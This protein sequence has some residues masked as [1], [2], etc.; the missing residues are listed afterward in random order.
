[1]ATSPS[2]PPLS[3]NRTLPFCLP[4]RL[5]FVAPTL[6]LHPPH[7]STSLLNMAY[8]P[9]QQGGYP[10]QPDYGRQAQN[11]QFVLD[12]QRAQAQAQAYA[13]E[14]ERQRQAYAHTTYEAPAPVQQ[15]AAP[16]LPTPIPTEYVSGLVWVGRWGGEGLE[17]GDGAAGLRGEPSE[18][19]KL[20]G[21]GWVVIGLL[22]A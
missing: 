12:Q 17:R 19:V 10:Q 7:T 21:V 2:R 9:P 11:P 22:R 5:A 8:R 18:S 14:R 16:Q 20:I 6:T 13:A 4:P 15:V 3:P 1:M